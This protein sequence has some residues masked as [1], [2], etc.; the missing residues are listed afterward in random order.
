[1]A[2]QHLP[3]IFLS[4]IAEP[5]NY[6]K[7]PSPITKKIPTRSRD[8]YAKTLERKFGRVWH[9]AKEQK[10][11]RTVMSLPT[12][13]GTYLEFEGSPGHE[14]VTKSLEDKR[15]GIRLLNVREELLPLEDKPV[16][17]ATVYVPAGKEV[18]F[19]K[20]LE[21]YSNPEKDGKQPR[22]ADLLNSVNDVRLAFLHSFWRDDPE[23]MPEGEALWCEI[24]LQGDTPDI[25]ESFRSIATNADIPV[26]EDALHFPERT[27]VL[28]KANRDNLR[29]LIDSCDLLA[30]F[31]LAKET[32]GFWLDLENSEQYEWV[33]NILG[34]LQTEPD[35]N[36]AVCILDAGANNGHPLLSP[37]LADED[38]H[39]VKLNWGT[40]DHHH[41]GHGTLM[42]GLAGYGDLQFALEDDGPI[43][44]PH[45]LESVKI[46]PPLTEEPNKPELYGARTTQAVSRVEI[47]APNRSHL[48]CMAVTSTDGRDRGRPSSWSAAIDS[49]SSGYDDNSQRLFIVAAGNVKEML[50]WQNYPDSNLTNSVHDPAQCWNALTVG[51]YTE[52]AFVKDPSYKD[53]KPIAKSGSLSPFSTTSLDWEGTKWPTK[54][55][56]VMEG[57]NLLIDPSGFCT[58]SEDTCLLSL[59]RTPLRKQFEP[60]YATS[61]ATAQAG[62]LAAQIQTRYPHAWPETIRGLMIHSAEWT[63]AMKTDFLGAKG[64]KGDYA[65]LMRICGHGVPNLTKALHCAENSLTLIAQE[66]I[67]PFGRKD[68]R[69]CTKDMHIFELPWPKDVLLE[70]GEVDVTLKITLS[71]FIEPSPGEVG[72]KDRYRYSSHAF[73][74]DLNN[75]GETKDQLKKRLT[76]DALEEGEKAETK[77]DSSRWTIGTIKR[78]LGSVHSDYWTG[79]AASL[80][81]CNIIGICPVI[82]WWR[83]RPWLNRL[84]KQARYSLIVSLHAPEQHLEQEIDIYTPVANEI[85]IAVPV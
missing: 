73:R 53:Y 32:A 41:E 61:S 43:H 55:D 79:S 2:D 77:G 15:S 42:C 57:G 1:M 58:I 7:A 5:T 13:T 46:L 63:E 54:P 21:E 6:T 59:S 22:N 40:H 29:E 33:K 80:A 67:Q 71:Y 45:N 24:W 25:E 52:K 66:T 14:L 8:E 78:H 10:D 11:D 28:A 23:L 3:H 30:E 16:T 20:K 26:Q 50:E 12:R 27:V 56:I 17:K 65:K 51:A 62:W 4:D 72:W 34:R 49:I 37:I 31:R 82:G 60:F 69:V 44:I 36:V 35:S 68:G 48:M 19:I 47:Q 64:N 84:E 74:F 39:A 38:C 70:L 85:A 9:D 83:E 18:R 81:D 75:P 76:V